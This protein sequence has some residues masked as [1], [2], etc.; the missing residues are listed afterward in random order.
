MN[1]Q[2]AIAAGED[3]SRHVKGPRMSQAVVYGGMVHV[4]GQIANDTT[5][6]IREQTRQVLAKIEA[7][8][9]EAGAGKADLVAV[10]VFLPHITDFDAMNEVYDAW[11]DPAAP[12]ARACVE[13]RLANP[14]LRVEMTAIA[15]ARS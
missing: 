8:I 11:I 10:N 6:D 2:T 3:I 12:P 5:A 9:A 1:E 7:L 4:A 15:A 13:A 14:D